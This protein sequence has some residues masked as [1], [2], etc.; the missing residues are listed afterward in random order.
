MS[1]SNA[2]GIDMWQVAIEYNHTVANLTGWSLPEGHIFSGKTFIS[3]E[4]DIADSASGNKYFLWGAQLMT[5]KVDVPDTGILCMLN[6][7]VVGE[8]YTRLRLGSE[9]QP[10]LTPSS[11]LDPTS[12]K[13]VPSFYCKLETTARD[14]NTGFPI[15]VS[16]P[17]EVKS[18]DLF[19][20]EAKV[21]PVAYFEMQTV[22][23]N[24]EGLYLIPSDA[25][26]FVNRPII[27]NASKSFDL[28]GEIVAYQWDFGD[29]NV[30]ISNSSIVYHVYNKASRSI[31]ITLQVIDDDGLVSEPYAR[32]IKVGMALTL[33][34]FGFYL[35]I[36][37]MIIVIL[38]VLLVVRRIIKRVSTKRRF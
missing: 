38:L 26:F 32:T 5:G 25:E 13:Y 30:T 34:N 36:F 8:G 17:L 16:I 37:A 9:E 23:F 12:G 20:G 35:E 22:P 28:D 18:S 31:T 6:F 27:F 3:P 7:T 19:V 24:K 1:V 29:G 2:I 10:I 11:K 33:I 14:P 4:P 15:K 21:P